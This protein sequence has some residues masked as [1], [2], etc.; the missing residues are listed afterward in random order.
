MKTLDEIAIHYQTD[1]ASQFSRTY[2][3]PHDYCRHLERFFEPMRD[4]PIKLVE[5][6]V[7]SGESIRTWLEYFRNEFAQVFGV[8]LN[9]NTNEWNTPTSKPD[10]RYT[11]VHGDQS[12]KV[13]WAS[14]IKMRGADWDVI[15]DDGSH[16]SSHITT[17]FYALWPHMKSGGVYIM[18]DLASAR[19]AASWV[20]GIA[21][22]A[23][24]G[25]GEADAAYF[26]RELA[27]LI[28]K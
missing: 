17:T 18:E 27:I 20:S 24:D 25:I 28:K 14:F 7:G 13:F 2:A 3:K 26:A 19:E 23:F 16:L 22:D 12:S 10:P 15:D 5:I 9:A 11:F 21:R 8:D 4:K 6:G 1:K